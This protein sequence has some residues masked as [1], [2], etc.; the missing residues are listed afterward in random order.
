MYWYSCVFSYVNLW[1]QNFRSKDV[2]TNEE[3]GIWRSWEGM[4]YRDHFTK[5]SGVFL[6]KPRL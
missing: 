4:I 3:H 2:G 1:K 5:L 6:M